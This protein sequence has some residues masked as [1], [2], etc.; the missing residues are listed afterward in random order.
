VLTPLFLNAGGQVGDALVQV[1]DHEAAVTTAGHKKVLAL[2]QEERAEAAAEM[3]C[4][5]FAS[6][7]VKV[8]M[9]ICI[10]V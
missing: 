10:I 2:V 6:D 4:A 5:G 7:W 1:G 9:H 3:V 8:R